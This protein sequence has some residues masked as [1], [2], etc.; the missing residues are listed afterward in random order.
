MKI[1]SDEIR[2]KEMKFV[3]VD[4]NQQMN[5]KNINAKYSISDFY[6]NDSIN[7]K[8]LTF[9]LNGDKNSLYSKIDWNPSTL[10]SSSIEWNTSVLGIDKYNVKILPS[11]FS[12]KEKKWDIVNKSAIS[13]NGTTID[14]GHFLIERDQ[15]YLSVDGRISKND[16]DHL[17]FRINDFKLDD[18]SSLLGSNVNIK[19]LVN[20][21][22][23]L[24]NPYKNLTYIGDANIQDLYVNNHEIGNIFIQT[25]W[26]TSSN[27]IGMTGDLI[28]KGNET[29]G[30][31]GNYYTNKPY[32]NLD[33]I[34][35]FDNT[36]IQFVNA[37]IDPE[38]IT[39]VKGLL[40]GNLNLNGSIEDPKIAGNVELVNG[41]ARLELLD[42]NYKLNGKIS[43]DEYG[44]YIN[45]NGN[46]QMTTF[47][48]R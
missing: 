38:I 12:L 15:Q 13:I 42:V 43:A 11:Y 27:S 16:E 35:V 22:G 40:V 29:F 19:G 34:L 44:F 31:D 46:K 17:N 24:S 26:E 6:L 23:Y 2:F 20:G 9:I 21:W 18:F 7:V 25:Q 39:D 3:G 47:F 14:I 33:F 30:F 1:N 8:N 45:I 5:S 41:N 10:N 4:V 32:D 48:A 37:F 28:Y 36:D